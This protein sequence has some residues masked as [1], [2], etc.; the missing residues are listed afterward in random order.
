MLDQKHYLLRYPAAA[1]SKLANAHS[2]SSEI[3]SAECGLFL[4][5]REKRGIHNGCCLV[6][7]HFTVLQVYYID[8]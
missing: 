4:G 5:E 8:D 3:T 1:I 7:A 2:L 6:M